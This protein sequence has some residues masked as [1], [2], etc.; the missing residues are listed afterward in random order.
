M[1]AFSDNSTD[2]SQLVNYLAEYF[3]IRDD[4]LNISSSKYQQSKSYCED[5]T[6][7]KFSFP[8]IYSILKDKSDNRLINILRQRTEDIEVKRYAV[9]YMKEC[10]ALEYTR[11]VLRNLREKIEKEIQNLGGH[12]HLSGLLVQLDLQ[13]D[14]EDDTNDDDSYNHRSD[15]GSGKVISSQSKGSYDDSPQIETL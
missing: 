5:L 1:Q 11:N 7:G 6:E 14:T 2:Y 15:S 9:Q 3:Q 10:G 12:R 13:L 8:I 4:F